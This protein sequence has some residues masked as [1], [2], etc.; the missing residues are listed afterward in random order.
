MTDNS[1]A[2]IKW[3]FRKSLIRIAAVRSSSNVS[4]ITVP[5][6]RNNVLLMMEFDSDDPYLV[7]S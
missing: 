7:I 1:K 5:V 2:N 6:K 3:K 4:T